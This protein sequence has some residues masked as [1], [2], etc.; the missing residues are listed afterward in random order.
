MAEH[1]LDS[2]VRFLPGVGA[3]RAERY[4]KLGVETIA[5]LLALYPR[6]Y[7][8]ASRP[9]PIRELVPGDQA[10]V[11]GVVRAAAV[12]RAR[13]MSIFTA[14]ID[15]G[16]GAVEALFFNQPFLEGTL[17]PGVSVL[18]H[19]EIARRGRLQIQPLEWWV[20]TPEAGGRI[21]PVY[22]ATEGLTQ[23]QI[24]A[25]VR[26]ALRRLRGR[27]P[28]ILPSAVLRAERLVPRE[29]ALRGLHAPESDAEVDAGRRRVIFEEF[30]LW[31]LALALLTSE[32]R[33]TAGA[34]PLR[35]DP[36]QAETRLRALLPFALTAAQER[37]T[38]EIAR[39]AGGTRPAGRLL[40]GDVGSG[41]TVV[42]ALA[43][44]RAVDSGCQGAL[45]APTQILAEQH[46]ATLAE[47]LDAAGVTVG[48]LT[49]A[50][51]GKAR[52]WLLRRLKSGELQV[53]VG[54]HALL[55]EDV[56]FRR[57]GLVIVD[58]QHRFGVEQRLGLAAKGVSPHVLV[59]TATPIPRS[60]ALSL[61]GDL[62]VSVLDEL[63]R[64]RRRVR[65]RLVPEARREA[66]HSFLRER[67][68]AG[69]QV[70]VVVPLVEESEA[71]D[72][73]AA[74]A[75]YE[76]YARD[77]FPGRGIGLVHGRLAPDERSRVMDRYRRGE[78]RLLVSTTVIEVGV[79]VP[80]ANVMVI[81]NAERF[82]LAQLHQLRG[83]VGRGEREAW[84]FLFASP[85]APPEA[86][87]RLE[88]LRRNADGF[89]IAEED[90]RLRGPGDFF[91]TQQH[92]VPRFVLADLARHGGI[93]ERAKAAAFELVERAPA[94]RGEELDSLRAALRRVYGEAARYYGQG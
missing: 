84:C 21:V 2:P 74:T 17:R 33:S 11:V 8:D 80:A 87:E 16:T 60:L 47:W 92:G 71:S 86:V 61:Y 44:T 64:G 42:A 62:D 59:M 63:P 20:T 30:F 40:Q 7:V 12:R 6:R 27:I 10:T 29:Q 51:K 57:L 76:R 48:L 88:L 34:P 43:L 81:E 72:L 66:L 4:A 90:L 37:V 78:I 24:R 1:A 83:R 69:E 14:A 70:F 22:P 19:G 26:E 79:D 58:E 46:A 32:R 73:Q 68:D 39:D 18:V 38:A 82:G 25:N 35:A 23:K 94:L 52:T 3:A 67:M 28:E 49:A 53:L 85:G 93:L 15:D 89:R 56:G 5:G 91:G 31:E 77:V 55:G 54:T 41:K 45:M 36:G 13:R 65:T 75:A 50:V 9:T